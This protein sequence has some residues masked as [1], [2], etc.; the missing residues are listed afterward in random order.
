MTTWENLEKAGALT[1][2]WQY[3]E[4][5][6]TYDQITDIDTGNYVYYEGLGM[7]TTWSNIAKTIS[8]LLIINLI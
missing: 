2:G 8:L 3:E 1:G 5:N 7:L 6:L 4:A